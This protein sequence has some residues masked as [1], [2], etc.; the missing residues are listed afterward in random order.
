MDRSAIFSACKA[1]L[2]ASGEIKALRQLQSLEQRVLESNGSVP[3][4]KKAIP[5]VACQTCRRAKARCVLSQP[6]STICDRCRSS[7][8]PCVV[9]PHKRGRRPSTKNIETNSEHTPA[10]TG[11]EPPSPSQST[12]SSPQSHVSS[13]SASDHNF[14]M[15]NTERLTPSVRSSLPRDDTVDPP[16]VNTAPHPL[17]FLSGPHPTFSIQSMLNP[18]SPSTTNT[19]PSM[20]SQDTGTTQLGDPITQG[21]VT[22]DLAQHLFSFFMDKL[23]SLVLLFDPSLHTFEYVRTKSAFLFTAILSSAAKF[24]S[25][26]VQPQLAQLTSTHSLQAILAPRRTIEI[27]Q[28]WMLIYFWKN[29]RDNHAWTYAGL[30][31]RMGVELGLDCTPVDD[32][33]NSTEFQ[34][35]ELRNR[36]RT[37]MLAFLIDRALASTTGRDWMIRGRDPIIRNHRRFSDHPHRVDGDAVLGGF[38]ELRLLAAEVVDLLY[39]GVD[40]TSHRPRVNIARELLRVNYDLNDWLHFWTGETERHRQPPMYI[41]MLRFFGLHVQL[42]LN[43]FAIA[44]PTRLAPVING[45][46][47]TPERYCYELAIGNLRQ[48]RVMHDLDPEVLR[49]MQDNLSI[50]VAYAA[51]FLWKVIN[52]TQFSDAERQ[53]ALSVIGSTSTMFRRVAASTSQFLQSLADNSPFSPRP[54]APSRSAKSMTSTT[55]SSTPFS[56]AQDV[57]MGSTSLSTP[58]E[59]RHVLPTSLFP[60]SGGEGQPMTTSTEME[61]LSALDGATWDQV[62]SSI[63]VMLSLRNWMANSD[64]SSLQYQD[65]AMN[66]SS[67]LFVDVQQ[68]QVGG[69]AGSISSGSSGGISNLVDPFSPSQV[70]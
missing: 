12:L 66:F 6:G 68:Y 42:T 39:P 3:V 52:S 33:P 7:G 11:E 21:L 63:C 45:D 50:M 5:F 49:Y 34:R 48:L 62:L 67:S 54:L 61:L 38:A 36:R 4:A 25:P 40:D 57:T 13:H 31:C 28:G 56:P 46:F 69:S 43:S 53:D 26:S 55:T 20:L 58:T 10:P 70:Y 41:A 23:N 51:S 29:V 30:A 18:V 24:F 1:E 32:P 19:V 44:Q 37:W 27:I 35:R 2:Q 64:N 47:Q 9:V 22:M 8:A 60:S 65:F 59:P 16:I 14:T 15:P 17:P